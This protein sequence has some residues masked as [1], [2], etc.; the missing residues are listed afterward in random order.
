LSEFFPKP[1]H[2]GQILNLGYA[3]T[4]TT[5]ARQLHDNAPTMRRYADLTQPMIHVFRWQ[6]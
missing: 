4:N 6:D 3:D 1:D 2:F 5:A